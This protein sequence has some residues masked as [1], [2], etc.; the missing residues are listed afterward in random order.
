MDNELY[1]DLIRIIK[2]SLPT[3]LVRFDLNFDDN[4]YG[5]DICPIPGAMIRLAIN[6][7]DHFSIFIK[8]YVTNTYK[9]TVD[10]SIIYCGRLPQKIKMIPLNK[11][12]DTDLVTKQMETD[13]FFIKQLLYNWQN[14]G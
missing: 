3:A 7:R 12:I 8:K 2:E 9:D 4:Y 5:W 14:I 6:G 11:Q 10:V 1:N 13:L